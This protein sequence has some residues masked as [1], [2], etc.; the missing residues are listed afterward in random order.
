MALDVQ[1]YAVAGSET[2]LQDHDQA[3]GLGQHPCPDCEVA[4]AQTEGDQPDRY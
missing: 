2:L 3:D 4:A 1:R